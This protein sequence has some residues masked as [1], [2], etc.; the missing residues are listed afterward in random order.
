[1]KEDGTITFSGVKGRYG[2][3]VIVDY[4]NETTIGYVE[5]SQWDRIFISESKS[6]VR[7]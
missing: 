6:M 4:G 5:A 1:M 3:P 2:I 7:R